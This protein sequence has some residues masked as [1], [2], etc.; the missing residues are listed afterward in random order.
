MGEEDSCDPRDTN[1]RT[2]TA[3][4]ARA[5]H[6]QAFLL[7]LLLSPMLFL[8][9]SPTKP[10]VMAKVAK[11]EACAKVE[12]AGQLPCFFSSAQAPDTRPRH[13][14]LRPTADSPCAPLRESW[15]A[16]GCWWRLRRPSTTT[17]SWPHQA[18]SP[19]ASTAR[20]ITAGHLRSSRR[21]GRSRPAAALP[22]SRR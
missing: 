2:H 19:G 20:P 22:R 21:R 11:S 17:S 7:L 5:A 8:I 3:P 16:P 9:L 6:T 12:L 14:A 13:S 15:C 18:A 1:D 4:T 10:R